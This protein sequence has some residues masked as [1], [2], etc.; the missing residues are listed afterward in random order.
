M[1]IARLGGSRFWRSDVTWLEAS[2][3]VDPASSQMAL[4]L[5]G[6]GEEDDDLY[7]SIN[8]QSPDAVFILQAEEC[9]WVVVNTEHEPSGDEGDADAAAP[10]QGAPAGDG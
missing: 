5:T 6:A 7:V 8:G 4:H 3:E 1:Q 10:D 9:W 2:G